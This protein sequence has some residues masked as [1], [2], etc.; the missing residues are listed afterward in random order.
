MKPLHWV[1]GRGLERH[2][3]QETNISDLIQLLTD[4]D[5][6]PWKDLVGF[7]PVAADRE[8]LKSDNKAD[9]L[10]TGEARSAVVEVKLGHLMSTEQQAAYESLASRPD[11]FQ[12][13]LSSDKVRLPSDTDRWEFLSLSEL[14]GAW[15]SSK[16]GF[17]RL[18]AAEAAKVLRSWDTV[19]AGVFA[20]RSSADW[21]PVSA[22]TQKF[23]ARVVTRRIERDLDE[24][25]RKDRRRWA[26]AM[27]TSGGG[28]PIVECWTP[29]RDESYDRSFIAEI[30]WS[31]TMPVGELRFGVDFD[32]RP[33]SVEDE[34]VRRAAYDLARSMDTAIDYEGL[35]AYLTEEEPELVKLVSGKGRG[36][37][38]ATGDFERVIVHGFA[39][40]P[41][42]DGSTNNRTKTHPDFLG[43]GAC[44]HEASATIDFGQASAL[45]L[46]ELIDAT[47]RYLS[48]QQP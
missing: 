8:G 39:G 32:P 3:A 25:D 14:I 31:E 43:D 17:A 20:E 26:R 27:V 18:L 16:D 13:A 42:T 34:E 48:S 7:V 24:K 11:L 30:R 22:L 12:A 29:I 28:R 40:A 36:R 44:R 47:L 23:L 2:L 19:M 21:Q 4:R 38:D 10:L 35:N 45:D 5:P 33:D 9:L 46:I 6:S 37:P 41:L 1:R 15:E